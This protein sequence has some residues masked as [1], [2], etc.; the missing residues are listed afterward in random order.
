MAYYIL[1]RTICGYMLS[2]QMAKI[3]INKTLKMFAIPFGGT[4]D[5]EMTHLT[6]NSRVTYSYFFCTDGKPI[7][8]EKSYI[9]FYN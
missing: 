8:N 2:D 3:K 7:C 6:I 9:L 4:I 5:T 1:S